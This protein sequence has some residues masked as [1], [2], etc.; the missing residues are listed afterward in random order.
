[1]V[2]DGVGETMSIWVSMASDSMVNLTLM[3]V[4]S[5]MVAPTWV[6]VGARKLNSGILISSPERDK[7]GLGRRG[8]RAGPRDLEAEVIRIRGL[9]PRNSA[10]LWGA[11]QVLSLLLGASKGE[12]TA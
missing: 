9:C 7:V 1:M 6:M 11:D 3:E 10:S 2:M 12:P 5:V 4:M 8:T